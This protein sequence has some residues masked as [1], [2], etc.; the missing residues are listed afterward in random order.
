MSSKY[1]QSHEN[2]NIHFVTIF[3]IVIKTVE[4]YNSSKKYK[5]IGKYNQAKPEHIS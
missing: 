3:I 4:K 2:Q 5:R 1:L